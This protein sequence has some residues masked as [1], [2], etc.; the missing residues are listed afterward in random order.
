M[1][2][3]WKKG[4]LGHLARLQLLRRVDV[5]PDH[6][7]IDIRVI[8]GHAEVSIRRS[9]GL[10]DDLPEALWPKECHET[11]YSHDSE[12]ADRSAMRLAESWLDRLTTDY[13]LW[14]VAL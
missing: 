14:G 2:L 9:G 11:F 5:P 4:I 7:L 6:S 13:W 3:N 1:I 12:I 8:G 10:R